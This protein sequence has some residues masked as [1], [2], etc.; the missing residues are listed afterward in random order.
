MKKI[1]IDSDTEERIKKLIVIESEKYRKDGT[2]Y[3]EEQMVNM[4]V[5][6][7][8]VL[9][10][11][12]QHSVNRVLRLPKEMIKKAE[13]SGINLADTLQEALIEKLRSGERGVMNNEKEKISKRRINGTIG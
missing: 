10:T 5:L 7:T 4:A 13:E 2:Y 3:T 11:P 8:L 9:K 6:T 12:L 1:N